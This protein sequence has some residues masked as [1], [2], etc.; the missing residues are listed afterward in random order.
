MRQSM[1]TPHV[2][3]DDS[4]K[5]T[6]IFN[7][8]IIKTNERKPSKDGK[9]STSIQRVIQPKTMQNK[10]AVQRSST[11][12]NESKK[13]K[14]FIN[15]CNVQFAAPNQQP[16]PIKNFNSGAIKN[17]GS[18]FESSPGKKLVKKEKSQ[19][20]DRS[21]KDR[22]NQKKSHLFNLGSKTSSQAGSKKQGSGRINSIFK[23][24]NKGGQKGAQADQ[25]KIKNV[26]RNLGIPKIDKA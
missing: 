13:S 16:F 3:R 9:K 24:A 26:S 2:A 18:K 22:F 12:N 15:L 5:R 1:A 10:Q 11:L 25:I 19:S 4:N 23:M 7:K 20:K 8:S 21:S 6:P 14:L 17:A